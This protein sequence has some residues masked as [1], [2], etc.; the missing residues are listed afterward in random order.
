[1][2][3]PFRQS[4]RAHRILDELK[5]LIEDGYARRALQRSP[6]LVLLNVDWYH[7]QMRPLMAKW[8]LLWLE[9][10]H[11]AGLSSTQIEG[12]LSAASPVTNVSL[13]PKAFKLLK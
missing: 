6:H 3:V 13:E 7:E 11:V 12:Y 10:N 1:M 5:A 9:A 8:M 4:G 2:S